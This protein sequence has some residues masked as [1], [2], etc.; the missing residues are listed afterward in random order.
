VFSFHITDTRDMNRTVCVNFYLNVY[1]FYVYM[2]YVRYFTAQL[3]PLQTRARLSLNTLP[4][5]NNHHIQ[6]NSLR[7]LIKNDIVCVFKNCGC[8]D[9]LYVLRPQ[10]ISLK[11]FPVF[12]WCFFV[13]VRIIALKT[14]LV[15]FGVQTVFPIKSYSTL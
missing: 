2:N 12:S 4:S 10:S 14:W 8:I 3:Q 9:S 5:K 7:S 15:I 1:T 13:C 6:K 11:T